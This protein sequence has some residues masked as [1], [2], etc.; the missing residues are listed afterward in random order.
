M[1]ISMINIKNR[2]LGKI[3]CT[4]DSWIL[5][6]NFKMLPTVDDQDV[7]FQATYTLKNDTWG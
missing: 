7:K 2:F 6:N 1:L 5:W 4:Q 3:K